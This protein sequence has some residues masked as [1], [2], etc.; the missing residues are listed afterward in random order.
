MLNSCQPKP[1]PER[2]VWGTIPNLDALL[3][4][5]DIYIHRIIHV[6]IELI[7]GLFVGCVVEFIVGMCVASCIKSKQMN[8]EYV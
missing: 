7:D 2:R 5:I 6:Y 8:S 1:H 4:V 3:W